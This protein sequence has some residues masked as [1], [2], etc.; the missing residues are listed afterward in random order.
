MTDNKPVANVAEKENPLESWKEIATYLRR[1]VRTVKRWEKSEGLPVHRHQHHARASVYAYPSELEAWKAKRQPEPGDARAAAPWRLA[2]ALALG[3]VLLLALMSIGSG[4]ILG[5]VG[6]AAQ[7]SSTPAQLAVRHVWTAGQYVGLWGS[8]LSPDGRYLT[9]TD[10]TTGDLAVHDLVTGENRRVTN[11]GPWSKA[12]EFAESF[13]RFSTDGKQVAYIWD[14]QGGYELRVINLDGTG[15]R[16]VYRNKEGKVRAYDWSAD[17]KYIAAVLPKASETST[18]RP[19]QIA[20]IRVADGSVRGV[21]DLNGRLPTNMSFSP[22]GRF[23]AFD[24]AA[25]GDPEKRDIFVLDLD[26]GQERPAIAHPADD[27]LLGWSPDGR[28]LLFASDR[29]GT[30]GAWLLQVEDGKP[31][32]GPELVRGDFGEGILP[33]GF[34]RSGAYYYASQ[35]TVQDVYTATADLAKDT[36]VDS[37]V[38]AAQQRLG[39]NA[40]P[41]WSPDGKFL[42][43]IHGGRRVQPESIVLRSLETGDERQLSPGTM[44]SYWTP[45]WGER[46]LRWSPDGRQLLANGTDNQ[47]RRGLFVIGVATGE[48]SPVAIGRRQRY[49]RWSHDGKAVFYVRLGGEKLIGQ[50]VRRQ[51]ETGQEKVLYSPD[52]PP[53]LDNITSLEPSPDG[54]WLAFSGYALGKDSGEETILMVMPA[55]GGEPKLLLQVPA[56]DLVK[57]VGWTPDGREVLFTRNLKMAKERSTALWRIRLEGGEPRKLELEMNVLNDIRFHPDGRRVAFDSGEPRAEIWVM[58]NFLP[59][60]GATKSQQEQ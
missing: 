8:S 45:G 26:G 21:R 24:L 13:T 17:G 44:K 20:L 40:G 22:D 6:V 38:P 35:D 1:D 55:E 3:A 25:N 43:Y 31:Q 60:A 50:I 56:S 57:V 48:A 2:P 30:T 4:P 37:P 18:D 42:A 47:N 58:E 9:Y 52:S 32:G 10:W 7:G 36:L 54:R 15:S 5:P 16:L 29:A 14:Q 41:E 33:F 49:G 59:E 53:L 39:S 23:L 27:R 19:V 46:Y 28:A 11:K 12:V 34:S 51:L